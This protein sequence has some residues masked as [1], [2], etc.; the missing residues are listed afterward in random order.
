MTNKQMT[1]AGAGLLAAGLGLGA[2]L[3]PRTGTAPS[4]PANALT[5]PVVPE[6]NGPPQVYILTQTGQPVGLGGVRL[7]V[8]WRPGSAPTP[9]KYR[10]DFTQSCAFGHFLLDG[11][12]AG[13]WTLIPGKAGYFFRPSLA[14]VTVSEATL[15]QFQDL[16]FEAVPLS[17]P[18]V[19]AGT[20]AARLA[21]R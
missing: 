11:L 4:A 7:S 13:T 17:A 18:A 14:T 8:T 21:S 12:T 9:P 6:D 19:P 16:R 20:Q 1:A 2:A 5:A 3:A 10:A 15:G